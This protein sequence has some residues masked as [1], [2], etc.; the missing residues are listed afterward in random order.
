MATA[1]IIEDD[2]LFREMVSKVLAEGG[3]EVMAAGDARNGLAQARVRTP[4]LVICDVH[5]EGQDGFDTLAALRSDPATEEVPFILMTG[6]IDGSLMR[7][8]MELG[9][10]DFLQKPF[11]PEI[12]LSAVNVRLQKHAERRRRTDETKERLFTILDAT[13]DLM[14]MSDAAGVL[15]DLN[16]AG[17]AMLELPPGASAASLTLEDIRPD[18]LNFIP[19]SD[20]VSEAV[21]KGVWRGEGVFL[22]RTGRKIPVSQV[23]VSHRDAAGAVDFLSTTARDISENRKQDEALRRS[24]ELFRVITENATDLIAIV[25]RHGRRLYNSPSYTSLLGFTPEEL[26]STNSFV[27]IHPEDRPAVMAAAAESLATD[28][29]KTVEYRMRHKDGRWLTFESHGAVIRNTAG[30]ID[31]LLIVGRDITERK[32]AE[33]AHTLMELQLRQAQKLE[34]IGQLASGIAHEINTPT[35][36]IGDNARFLAD[37]FHDLRELR[38]KYRELHEAVRSGTAT[39]EL[40]T[41][42]DDVMRQIDLDYRQSLDGVQRV[43]KIVMAMKEFSHPGTQE[44]V[45]ADLNRAIESTVTVARNVWKYV[46][47]LDLQ[48]DPAL[49]QIPCLPGEFNQVILNLV[50]NAAHAIEDVVGNNSGLKGR[51][52]VSTRLD[53][54]WAE[55][56]VTDTGTG[57]PEHVRERIF[58]PFFTTKGVG[59]GTGQGLAITRSAIVDKH[60]GTIAF[61]TRMGAGTTFILR[62]PVRPADA[63]R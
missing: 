46:A 25:D 42:I 41:E 31:G 50:V 34:S 3:L 28:K 10:D 61:D 40:V 45:P 38:V 11:S 52:T 21:Q 2:P 15:L 29:G 33:H 7:Q 59:K 56:R 44:K 62:L 58:D 18:A 60:G 24:E 39:P 22:S 20:V 53:G 30:E 32:K 5:L 51:I 1:L 17:R 37:A 55:I 54:D 57:I 47:D 23:I 12:L 49:P 63:P 4:D 16:R 8:G 19:T 26:Q 43:A 48:L 6:Q 35:Q 13:P 9:A 27:Q 14:A 36:F